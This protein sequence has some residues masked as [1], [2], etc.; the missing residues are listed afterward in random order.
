[1]FSL[2]GFY[3]YFG[4]NCYLHLLVL[5]Y[6]RLHKV[7]HKS[8]RKAENVAL[9]IIPAIEMLSNSLNHGMASQLIST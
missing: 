3:H 6:S 1:M 4:R 8:T 7:H 5:L 9:K 2:V